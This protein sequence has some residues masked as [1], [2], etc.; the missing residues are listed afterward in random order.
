MEDVVRDME[1]VRK[2]TAVVNMD[3]A[4]K[5]TVIVRS[6]KDVNLNLVTVPVKLLKLQ[7]LKL[8]HLLLLQTK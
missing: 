6:K 5:L 2:T 8:I 3:G 7:L 1:L 4:V